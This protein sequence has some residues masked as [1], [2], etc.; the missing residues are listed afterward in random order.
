MYQ[1]KNDASRSRTAFAHAKELRPKSRV[2]LAGLLSADLAEKKFDSARTKIESALAESP[3]DAPLQILAG[4]TYLEIGDTKRAEAAFETALQIDPKN[5]EAFSK[6]GVLY[7]ASGRLEEAKKKYEELARINDKPV[8]AMTLL[9]MIFELE[10]NPTEARARYQRALELDSR[11][12]VAANNLAWM[13]AESGENLDVALQLAQTAKSQLPDV[14]AIND[15]LGW[16]YYKKGMWSQAVLFLQE[17]NK[18]G[19]PTSGT[20]YRLGLSYM[21]AGDKKNARASFE[22]A[23]KLKPQ[24]QEE[25]GL[26]QALA[27]LKG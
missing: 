24:P 13:Y 21:K 23:L 15:T 18:H 22:Q 8:A 9:G 16:L 6:L 11:A 19:A 4:N 12:A 14:A 2:A 27:A 5:L 1:A 25:E 10:K 20:Q 17:A 7:H 26:K 3:K